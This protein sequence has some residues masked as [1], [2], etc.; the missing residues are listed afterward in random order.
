[1]SDEPK[2]KDDRD[3]EE[4]ERKE[5]EKKKVFHAEEQGISLLIVRA[6]LNDAAEQSPKSQAR[7]EPW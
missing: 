7:N 4:R 3:D 1:V 2:T 5:G 6:T